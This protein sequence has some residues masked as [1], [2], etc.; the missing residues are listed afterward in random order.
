MSEEE[1]LYHSKFFKQLKQQVVIY[2]AIGLL[3]VAGTAIGFYYNTQN[4][5][6]TIITNQNTI[7]GTQ[8]E[9][10][11]DLNDLREKKIDKADYIREVDEV[12][13]M[14]RNLEDKIDKL[15]R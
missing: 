7:M 6:S 14:L 15:K 2:A 4:T 11:R 1:E 8:E 3:T 5:I 13:T 9:F 10:K 12:K